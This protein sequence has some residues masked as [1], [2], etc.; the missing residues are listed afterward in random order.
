MDKF[1]RK[2]NVEV[3]RKWVYYQIMNDPR[4]TL[5]I[6]DSRTYK[7][8]YKNKVARFVVWPNG[9]IE[10]AIVEGENLLFYLH[11]QFYTF[12][13]AI[14]LFYRFIDKLTDDKIV[15]KKK[16]L[17]CCTGGM[18]TGYFAEKMN[19][20]CE[21]R[22]L[23]YDIQATAYY[24]LKNIYHNYSLILIAPQLRY[25]VNQ[26]MIELSPVKVDAIDARTFATYNCQA[27]LKQ[28][29]D[30]EKDTTD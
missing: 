23:P 27:L 4:L 20:Y 10:E 2:E 12:P 5:E 9:I 13:Y 18:T 30:E 14:E 28:I 16:I 3:F 1:Y 11:F 26:L 25:R 17:L 15:S 8:F 19:A 21:A 6:R 7:V 22:N 29:Q 24:H